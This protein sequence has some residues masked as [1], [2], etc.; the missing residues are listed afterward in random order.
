M[1]ELV[2]LTETRYI[3]AGDFNAAGQVSAHFKNLLKQLGI[4]SAI[5]RKV[6]IVS[7]E[8]ELNL[9]IH[10]FGGKMTLSVYPDRIWLYVSDTGPGIENIELAMQK[11]YSTA[12][13]EVRMLGFGAGMG[14]YNIERCTDILDIVSA[15]GEGTS[16]TMG[17]NIA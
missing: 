5:I 11:G 17:F 9:T 6:S 7:Y 2:T 12:S 16:I 13:E 1:E 3:T 8:A 14:F 10:S 4:N 15:L